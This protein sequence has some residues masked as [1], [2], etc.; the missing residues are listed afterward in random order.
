MGETQ[1]R[2]SAPPQGGSQAPVTAGEG[3]DVETDAGPADLLIV[4]ESGRFVAVLDGQEVGTLR[5]RELPG[6]W[7]LYSTY[8]SPRVRGRGIAG[9]LVRTALD[10]ARAAGV[11]VVPT[12]SYIPVWLRRHPGYADLAVAG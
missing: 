1:T 11:K 4:R 8:A 10:E 9:E 2:P 3:S 6:V 12:C 5:V 7:D